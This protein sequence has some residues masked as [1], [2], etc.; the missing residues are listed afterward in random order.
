MAHPTNTKY[1]EGKKR[2]GKNKT[3]WI[4]L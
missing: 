3:A 2:R 1:K 4:E